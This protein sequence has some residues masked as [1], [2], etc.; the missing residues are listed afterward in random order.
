MV[1]D[2]IKRL[3][4]RDAAVPRRVPDGVRVYA[5][6]DLHGRLDLF[7]AM[8]AR[9]D[10]DRA[11]WAGRVEVVLL[12]DYVDRG[13]D[14]AGLLDRLAAPLPDWARWTLLRGN[15]EQAMLDAIDGI[16]GDRALQLWLDNGG[17][18]AVKSYG[19]PALIAYGSDLPLLIK[20][21]RG[22]V[23]ARHVAL[24]RGLP[25]THRIGDY[26]FVHA[27]IRPGVPIEAQE[28]RD[29]LWIRGEFLDCRDDHGC[30]VVHGHSITPQPDERANRIGIDTG[31]YATGRLTALVLEGSARRYLTAAVADGGA[32]RFLYRPFIR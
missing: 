24:L 9:I 31:A 15:H 6:G 25:L 7:E 20:R 12:G 11:G 2:R 23:P 17:R 13:A 3:L 14:S 22:R 26:L 1:A 5:I 19:V 16:G 29:L 28:E 30:L 18:E 32:D 21:L 4:A 8:V 10:A 27:G